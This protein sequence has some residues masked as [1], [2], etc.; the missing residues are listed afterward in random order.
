MTPFAV[1][2]VGG[3][4]GPNPLPLF[5]V[6]TATDADDGVDDADDDITDDTDGVAEELAV[7][8]IGV[9]PFSVI[10]ALDATAT[11][12]VTTAVAGCMGFDDDFMKNFSSLALMCLP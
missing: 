7:T 5:A 8:A 12:V 1:A 11:D 9:M 6:A 4:I 3:P 2:T 10:I